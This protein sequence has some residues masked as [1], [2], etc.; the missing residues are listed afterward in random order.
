MHRVEVLPFE[1]GQLE[2]TEKVGVNKI[3]WNVFGRAGLHAHTLDNDPVKRAMERK[4]EARRIGSLAGKKKYLTLGHGR[5]DAGRRS[6][7]DGSLISPSKFCSGS[8]RLFGPDNE[9]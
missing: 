1:Y 5:N 7:L 8:S 9:L 2:Q 6:M 4:P 3:S